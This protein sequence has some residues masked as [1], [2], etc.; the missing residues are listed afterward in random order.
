MWKNGASEDAPCLEVVIVDRSLPL[1]DLDVAAY[2][3][4]VN[5]CRSGNRRPKPEPALPF[6]PIAFEVRPHPARVGFH[7]TVDFGPSGKLNPDIAAGRFGGDLVVGVDDVPHRSDVAGG[8][9][10]LRA[11]AEPRSH[12][13]RPKRWRYR[14]RPAPPEKNTSPEAELKSSVST[15]RSNRTSTSPDAVPADSRRIAPRTTTSPDA[16]VQLSSAVSKNHP[17][18]SHSPEGGAGVDLHVLGHPHFDPGSNSIVVASP[19]PPLSATVSEVSRVDEYSAAG[20]GPCREIKSFEKIVGLSLAR[21]VDLNGYRDL[22]RGFV[23]GVDDQI[24]D[25]EFDLHEIPVLRGET[26]CVGIAGVGGLT[27]D[28]EQRAPQRM[29]VACSV[30]FELRGS[31]GPSRKKNGGNCPFVPV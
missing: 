28:G 27:R 3:L 2:R 25:R 5:D 30:Q 13:S 17:D 19:V 12:R 6:G 21:G 9:G 14:P 22:D 16:L 23:V 26:F 18:T 7:L 20:L 4:G 11:A 10:H 24:V 1:H 29:R 31:M 15:G 8:R